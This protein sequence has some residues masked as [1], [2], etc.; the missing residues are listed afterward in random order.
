MNEHERLPKLLAYKSI[1]SEAR[2]MR[3]N[4][5]FYG[6]NEKNNNGHSDTRIILDFI[7]RELGINAQDVLIDRAHRLGQLRFTPIHRRGDPK[8]PIIARLHNYQDTEEILQKAYRLRGKSYGIDRQYPQE[9]MEA[10]KD[11]YNSQSAEDARQNR[12]KVQ[13]RYPAR[14]YIEGRFV[15]DRFPDWFT[16]LRGS[17][18]PEQFTDQSQQQI[19]QPTQTENNQRERE[20]MYSSSTVIDSPHRNSV[21]ETPE[22]HAH[23]EVNSSQ[24]VNIVHVHDSLS[25]DTSVNEGASTIQTNTQ[26]N[27]PSEQV[28]V[29]RNRNR[30]RSRSQSRYSQTNTL[31]PNS[32]EYTHEGATQGM[33]TRSRPS[34]KN[35]HRENQSREKPADSTQP[36]T[37]QR[38]QK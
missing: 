33:E 22:R 30:A 1:D 14:L 35:R 21:F 29:I 12:K 17:R 16:I 8:R 20:R 37:G 15:A 24:N 26:T 27:L 18:I 19:K 32:Q 9:I 2:D 10:R 11:L 31:N 25:R 38:S 6:I 13:I 4:L 34:S 28:D 7:K 36:D 3:N 23:S 5:I